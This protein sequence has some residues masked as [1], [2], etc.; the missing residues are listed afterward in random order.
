MFL[1]FI[2]I[3]LL[4]VS[5]SFVRTLCGLALLGLSSLL[6]TDVL[7]LNAISVVIYLVFFGGM[8]YGTKGAMKECFV[9]L[10]FPGLVLIYQFYSTQEAGFVRYEPSHSGYLTWMRSW[11]ASEKSEYERF[12][13]DI[14]TTE[15]FGF[16][17]ANYPT[18]AFESIAERNRVAELLKV[19]R[20]EG[21]STSIDSGFRDIGFERFVQHPVRSFLLVPALRMANFWINLDGAQSY[22][23][24]IHIQ[25]PFSLLIVAFTLLMRL[26][27]ILMAGLGAYVIW[28][29]PQ[30]S[31]VDQLAFSTLWEPLCRT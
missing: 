2:G 4:F 3:W 1:D 29:Q 20:S 5:S 14:G 6:R 25:R 9:F 30:T 8:K 15:W 10:M 17:V 7:V 12:A 11:F 26:L 21:Y 19:W 31:V 16:D 27:L 28:F 13:W 23:Q 24:V 22:F 18:R